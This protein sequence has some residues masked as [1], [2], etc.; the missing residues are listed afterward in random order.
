MQTTSHRARLSEAPR[1][2]E[3]VWVNHCSPELGEFTNRFRTYSSGWIGMFTGGYYDLGFDPWPKNQTGFA[4]A[5]PGSTF[6]LVRRGNGSFPRGFAPPFFV[7][8]FF[9][10]P[11]FSLFSTNEKKNQGDTRHE[12]QRIRFRPQLAIFLLHAAQKSSD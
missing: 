7:F 12:M 6:G 10:G 2:V 3:P 9:F 4:G 8:A 1:Q 11:R 5:L